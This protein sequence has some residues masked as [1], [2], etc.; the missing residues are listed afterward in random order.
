MLAVFVPFTVGLYLF[1]M[2]S[3]SHSVSVQQGCVVDRTVREWDHKTL[4]TR[5]VCR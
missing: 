5:K 3:T 1:E 2:H 4:S